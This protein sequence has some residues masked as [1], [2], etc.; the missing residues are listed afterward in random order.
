MTRARSWVA[1]LATTTLAAGCGVVGTGS[2]SAGG[3]AV[4][5][6]PPGTASPSV[7]VDPTPTPSPTPPPVPA[8]WQPSSGEVSTALKTAAATVAHR[9][10]N[11]EQGT[12]AERLAARVV[13]GS[14]GR[15][16]LVTALDP[17]VDPQR[18][19]RGEVVYP[20]LGGLAPG[21]CVPNPEAASVMVVVR[22]RL[23]RGASV[24]E[25]VTRTL[26]V[27][28][29]TDDEGGWRFTELASAGGRPAERPPDL[30]P[31]GAAVVDDSRIVLPD[32]AV[33]DIYR[34]EVSGD[35][36]DVMRRLAERTPYAVTVLKSGHPVNVFAQNYRSDHTDGR[37]VDVYAIGGR[38][39][40]DSRALGTEP[41]SCGPG[42]PERGAVHEHVAWLLG[43]E[44]VNQVGS[45]WD[46]D[47][48][49]QASFNDL[50]HQDHLHISAGRRG[51]ASASPSE[52]AGDG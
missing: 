36:L 31:A 37:A 43:L 22:Q 24:L 51:W 44:P 11:Y 27:R 3:P 42:A 40:V 50:V 10:T 46:L 15:R 1:L 52:P 16:S 20:Q 28:L 29:I 47:P 32:S 25:T 4:T 21:P 5:A 45:P 9:L 39:V 30:S 18:W 34:G 19:S 48:P 14:G 7:T 6:T 17:L 49:Q 23:G 8:R 2:P 33:W 12:T 26:D 38:P 41:P 35:V 13:S